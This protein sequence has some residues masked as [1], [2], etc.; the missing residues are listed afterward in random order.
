M[1]MKSLWWLETKTA[2]VRLPQIPIIL[3]PVNQLEMMNYFMAHV[4]F[5]KNRFLRLGLLKKPMSENVT[6]KPPH[7]KGKIDGTKTLIDSFN[8]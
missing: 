2:G 5:L 8:F 6:E 1:T 7:V 3:K 4:K